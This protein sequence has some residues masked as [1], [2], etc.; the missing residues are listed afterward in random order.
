MFFLDLEGDEAD[1]P[2]AAAIASVAEHVER[3]RVLGSYPA[4]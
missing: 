2:V 1:Q 4:A 3:V